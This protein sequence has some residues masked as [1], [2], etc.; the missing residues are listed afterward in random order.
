MTEIKSIKPIKPEL[1]GLIEEFLNFEEYQIIFKQ[2]AA[3]LGYK[4]DEKIEIMKLLFIPSEDGELGFAVE[5][6]HDLFL[7]FQLIKQLIDKEPYKSLLL[8]YPEA[9]QNVRI[10]AVK[11]L[12][13]EDIGEE[14]LIMVFNTDAYAK[15]RAEIDSAEAASSQQV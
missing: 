4:G 10:V 5:G 3:I 7:E 9:I 15:R 12:N 14:D 6:M 1:R 2:F 13:Q 8:E 11:I